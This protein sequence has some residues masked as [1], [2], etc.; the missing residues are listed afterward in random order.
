VDV[1]ACETLI[2][3]LNRWLERLDGGLSILPDGERQYAAGMG[4]WRGVSEFF[5]DEE[6]LDAVDALEDKYRSLQALP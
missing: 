6:L 2:S 5:D 1:S 4:L 3:L